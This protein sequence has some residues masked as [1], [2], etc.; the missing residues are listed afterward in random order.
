[1]LRRRL[2]SALRSPY[3]T[4]PL[5]GRSSAAAMDISVDFPAPFGPSSATISPAVQVNDTRLSAHR[6]PKV[7]ETLVKL[8]EVKSTSSGCVAIDLRVD[9]LERSH[10]LLTA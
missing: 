4:V 10:Q 1:M 5:D 3:R 2:T 9:A 8:S 7:R 6:R